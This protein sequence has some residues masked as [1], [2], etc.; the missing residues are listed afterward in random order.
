[1]KQFM[2]ET[3]KKE[4]EKFMEEFNMVWASGKFSPQQQDAIYKTSNAMLRKRLKAFPD[5][6]NYLSALISF[7]KSTQSAASFSAWQASLDKL[8][9]LPA[10][11]FTNYI[12]TCNIILTK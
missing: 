8:L 5:F 2:Q 11:N 1:M 4:G 3:D 12:I 6:K 9:L 10:R 7:S